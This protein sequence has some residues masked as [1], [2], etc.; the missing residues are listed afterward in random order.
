[1]Y[2]CVLKAKSIFRGFSASRIVPLNSNLFIL[3]KKKKEVHITWA[4]IQQL[5]SKRLKYT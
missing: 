3:I 2:E 4:W 5:I 1:M